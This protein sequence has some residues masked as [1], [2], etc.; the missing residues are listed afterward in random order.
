MNTITKG[1]EHM[2]I[3]TNAVLTLLIVT[4]SAVSAHAALSE[5]DGQSGLSI[6][7][8]ENSPALRNLDQLLN[9]ENH[10]DLFGLVLNQHA[11]AAQPANSTMDG[12]FERE[13]AEHPVAFKR[14]D[15]TG[16]PV[17]TAASADSPNVSL[18]IAANRA[19]QYDDG[20]A[21]VSSIGTSAAG[22]DRSLA[23]TGNTT[24]NAV[25]VAPVPLPASALFLAS[26]LVLLPSVRRKKQNR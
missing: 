11:T 8:T 12:H 26:G 7:T 15:R 20:A 3:T 14:L 2:K 1:N 13:G 19:V 10:S 25:L 17:T 21:A 18:T 23:V 4:I 6:E 9:G 24:N 5:D 22:S 16:L